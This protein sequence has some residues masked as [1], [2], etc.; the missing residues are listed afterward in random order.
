MKID[1]K[2]MPKV[3]V[4]GVLGVGCIGYAISSLTSGASATPSAAATTEKKDADTKQ[5]ASGT[6]S[7]TSASNPDNEQLIQLAKLNEPLI[8]RDPFTP[9]GPAALVQTPAPTPIPAAVPNLPKNTG[10]FDGTA[11]YNPSRPA[12]NSNNGQQNPTPAPLAIPSP[13]PPTF[14]ITAVMVDSKPG[15][16]IA[17]LRNGDERRFVSEGDPVGNGFVVAAIR[18]NQVELV[19]QKNASRRFSFKL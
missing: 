13:P 3:A 5:A 6:V 12:D 15:D 8:P 17:V 16:S 9:S 19:D 7:G 1:K 10:K 18:K 2:D 14:T 11:I 4:L